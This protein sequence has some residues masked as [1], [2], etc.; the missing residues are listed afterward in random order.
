[1]DAEWRSKLTN[2]A[3]GSSEN[4]ARVQHDS[5]NQIPDDESKRNKRQIVLDWLPEQARI[6]EADGRNHNARTQRQPERPEDRTAIAL[7]DVVPSQCSPQ[8]PSYQA[9]FDVLRS[10]E[11][12]RAQTRLRLRDIE[13]DLFAGFDL[14]TRPRRFADAAFVRAG[15]GVGSHLPVAPSMSAF[16]VLAAC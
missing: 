3:F 7:T 13:R 12:P 1:M 4:N 16:A 6:Y 15:R 14:P 2:D 5:G 11:A 8:L 10:L 9:V